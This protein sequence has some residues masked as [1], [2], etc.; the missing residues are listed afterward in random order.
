M[1][2]APGSGSLPAALV[3]QLAPTWTRAIPIVITSRCVAGHNHDDHLHR[4]GFA[5]AQG[6][7][8]AQNTFAMSSILNMYISVP[9]DKIGSWMSLSKSIHQEIGARVWGVR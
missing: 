8:Q 5:F 4:S 7:S 6:S 3:E 1:I 9:L 2:A